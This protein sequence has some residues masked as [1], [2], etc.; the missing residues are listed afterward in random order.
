MTTYME[1]SNLDIKTLKSMT[2]YMEQSNLDD[3]F[4]HN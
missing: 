1:Q 3:C 2:I 4:W